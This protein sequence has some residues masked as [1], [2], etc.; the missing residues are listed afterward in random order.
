MKLSVRMSGIR[1]LFLPAGIDP[2]KMQR[3]RLFDYG[4]QEQLE[5]CELQNT[6][7]FARTW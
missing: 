1:V 4:T 3:R 5:D 6:R 2:D 7:I